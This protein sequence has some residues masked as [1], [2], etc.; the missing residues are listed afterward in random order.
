MLQ[1]PEPVYLSRGIHGAPEDVWRRRLRD[2]G[3]TAV[4]VLSRADCR[5][6]EYLTVDVERCAPIG[7]PAPA[8]QN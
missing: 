1:N 5:K 2:H 6:I 8:E 3:K 7:R 4:V